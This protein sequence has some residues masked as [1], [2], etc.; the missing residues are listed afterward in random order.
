MES[1]LGSAKADVIGRC[2]ICGHVANIFELPGRAEKYCLDCSPDL[3]SV[4]VLADE[5]DAA[6]LSG[7]NA[8]TLISEFEEI[9]SRMLV[10]AQS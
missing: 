10:R 7:T 8:S 5:I 6:T 4:A 1:N 2:S 9:S 3:A